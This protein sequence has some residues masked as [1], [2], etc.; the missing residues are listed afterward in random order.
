MF[1]CIYTGYPHPFPRIFVSL[2]IFASANINHSNDVLYL[3]LIKMYTRTFS[4]I[5]E[6]VR[7]HLCLR[8]SHNF[9][10]MTS[11]AID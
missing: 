4:L 7:I 5:S 3:Y 9:T 1:A 2:A 10:S 8:S 11:R 6:V